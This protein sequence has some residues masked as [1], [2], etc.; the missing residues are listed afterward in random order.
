[1]TTETRKKWIA[2]AIVL[3]LLPGSAL[4]L[5]ASEARATLSGIVHAGSEHAPLAGVR[6]LAGDRLSNAVFA[7]QPTTNDGSF[8]IAGLPAA[9]YEL[10][11]E[12]RGGLYVVAAPLALPAGE[13]RAVGIAIAAE[14]PADDAPPPPPASGGKGLTFWNNPATAALLVLGVA[15][16]FG[17]VIE[18]ATDDD[19]A[20]SSPFEP[21]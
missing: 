19:D 10:A 4:P 2:G 5:A 14:T 13:R 9:T 21:E 1:M 20:E 18:N 11:V 3:G 6:V 15:I 8:E 16:V 12:S 7:S 17:V